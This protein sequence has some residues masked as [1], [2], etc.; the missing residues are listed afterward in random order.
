MEKFMGYITLKEGVPLVVTDPDSCPVNHVEIGGFLPGEW[1]CEVTLDEGRVVSSCISAK[2][3]WDD[4]DGAPEYVG[5]IGIDSGLAGFYQNKPDYE[6]DAWSD[7]C[8]RFYRT[9]AET[10]LSAMLDDTGFTT[11]SGLGDG[12]Y[13]VYIRQN[14]SGHA[15]VVEII[16]ED[17]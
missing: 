13:P 17:D 16:F 5:S 1:E 9:E 6:D 8:D 12:W 11:T 14:K 3:A 10:G 2:D 7:F 15:V 4:L